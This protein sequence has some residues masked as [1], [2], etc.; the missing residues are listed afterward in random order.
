MKKS[1]QIQFHYQFQGNSQKPL[2]LLLHGFLGSSDDWT[3]VIKYLSQHFYC[4]AIDLLGHGKTKLLTKMNISF[5]ETASSIIEFLDQQNI[6][7]CFL[8]GYSMGGRLALLLTLRYP[9]YFRK[10]VLE[11]ASPG[12]RTE[13]E[14]QERIIQDEKIAKDLELRDINLFLKKWYEQPIFR[15]LADH[16]NYPQLLQ[17]RKDSDLSMLANS[18]RFLGTGKQPSLWGEIYQNKIPILLITGKDDI[19]FQN[20]AY[21]MA[22]LN[23][24]IKVEVIAKCSHNVHF[25]RTGK[26]AKRLYQFFK[27]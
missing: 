3:E 10:V 17:K 2:I 4:L 21:K 5:E 14:R 13:K 26:F 20:I 11:S 9:Q 25:Q 22:K 7:K 27:Y 19:K 8:T 16:K 24:F 15:G 18:L 1:P 6:D 23:E 12:L